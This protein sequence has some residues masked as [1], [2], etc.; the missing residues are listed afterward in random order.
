MKKS[1]NH[2]SRHCQNSNRRCYL[3]L[4][5]FFRLVVLLLVVLLLVVLSLVVM[6]LD[7]VIFP[8]MGLDS[9]HVVDLDVILDQD[10]SSFLC[11]NLC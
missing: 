1:P 5:A 3:L 10:S 6:V 2:S 4:V 8:L 11:P 7:Q 9:D